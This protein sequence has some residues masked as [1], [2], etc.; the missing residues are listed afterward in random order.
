[1][2]KMPKMNLWVDAFN[3]D[4]C[5]L[6]NEE[7]GIY[8]RLIFFAWSR[9]GY[10]PDDIEFIYCLAPNAE[11]KT[12]DKVM[13]LYWTKDG[14]R[15][16]YQKRLREEYLRAE[17]VT[18]K[19][20]QNAQSRY[21]TAERPQSDRTPSISKS[22]SKS[23][24]DIIERHFDKF[25]EDICYKISK[26]Q[27]RRNYRKLHQDWWEEPKML[28]E[29]YNEYYNN[30]SDKKFA[31]YPSTWL[32]AEGYLDE[33][34]EVKEKMTEQ[35]LKDWKFKG[36]IE[37]RKKGIKPLSWSVGYIRELDEAIAKNGET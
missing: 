23:N 11:E 29:K 32:S 33:K 17:E 14:E 20:R 9:G 19:N 31:K 37:M 24:K 2:S 3:S 7:L 25:W 13:K 30:L 21:A 10:L 35:E 4:T 26:G 1:M 22:I 34:A 28:S 12:I 18:E 15:G 36:D 5:F 6:S 27:A 8:F 16:Y